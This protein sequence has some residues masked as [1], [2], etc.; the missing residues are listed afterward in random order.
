MNRKY[1]SLMI[2]F[3]IGAVI[4]ITPHPAEITSQAWHLLAIFVATIIGFMLQPIPIGGLAFLSLTLSAL[5]GTLKISEVLSAFS[6]PSAWLIASAFLFS[7]SFR[8]TNLG[9]R[10][11]FVL[12]EKFGN[13]TLKL[14]YALIISDMIVAPVTPSNTA[15]A[16]GLFFPIV[17]SLCSTYG[18]EPGSTGKKI[19]RFMVQ[20]MFHG[21]NL[22]S[23]L[24]MTAMAGNPL[25]V[26]FVNKISGA[27][28]SWGLWLL[29]TSIPVLVALII[30]PLFL[31]YV[32]EVPE[33]KR[34]PDA[35]ALALKELE[36][37]GKVTFAEK[38]LMVI[39]I[40]ALILWS[41]SQWTHINATTVA[42]VAVSLM[43]LTDV[44]KW[45]DVI[46]E[47]NSWNV[48]IWMGGLMCLAGF[49]SKLGLIPWVAKQS[50]VYLEQFSWGYALAIISIVYVIIHYLFAS[51]VAHIA[52]LFSAFFAVTQVLGAP[53]YLAAFILI[54]ANTA[55]QGL[56]HYSVGAAPIFYGAGYTTQGEW[57]RNGLILTMLE[58]SILSGVGLLWLKILGLY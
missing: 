29:A 55:M 42:L 26:E 12:I 39:F 58:N 34:T 4:W 32:L 57:W 28:I 23:G 38:C 2:T 30:I 19:G 16:G 35:R 5:T 50:A 56:T 3:G 47:K 21:D 22:I 18:S 53:P 11:S 17:R 40:I 52:A 15:R 41:T 27:Q 51:L 43:L 10:I 25:M 46:E 48:L 31:Y 33:I 6:N 45:S 24:Y 44:L 9:R 8:K 7:R 49:L 36:K 1:I 54:F 14:L 20:G 37:M 13:S